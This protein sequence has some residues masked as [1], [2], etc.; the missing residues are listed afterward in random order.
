MTSKKCDCFCL[1][2]ICWCRVLLWKCLVM[3]YILSYFRWKTRKCKQSR[4]GESSCWSLGSET[5]DRDK[6]PETRGVPRQVSSW[7]ARDLRLPALC[8]W[9]RYKHLAPAPGLCPPRHGG[10]CGHARPQP[11]RRPRPRL[12]GRARALLPQ[13]VPQLGAVPLQGD[14]IGIM[15]SNRYDLLPQNVYAIILPARILAN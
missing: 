9:I 6:T 5:G 11:H 13:P 4:A 8:S 12:R 7:R 3:F 1:W 14:N 10:Q 15:V 2:L